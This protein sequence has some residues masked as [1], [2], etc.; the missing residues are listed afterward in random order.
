MGIKHTGIA[1][2]A[3]G[4]AITGAIAAPPLFSNSFE[5]PETDPSAIPDAR[6][7][8]VVGA[9]REAARAASERAS[10]ARRASGQAKRLAGL[11]SVLG[12][13]A[14]PMTVDD[15]TV[16]TINRNGFGTFGTVQFPSGAVFIG[17]VGQGEGRYAPS[18]ESK[19]T[20]FSGYVWGVETAYPRPIEGIFEFKTGESFTGTLSGS[21]ARG[22]YLSADGMRRFVGTMIVEADSPRPVAGIVEDRNRGLLAV[23]RENRN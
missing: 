21:E 23:V 15:Q 8:D 17:E 3:Y 16:A 2:L 20:A 12:V 9:G 7:T 11:K 18:P 6:L 22:I 19:L 1:A 10:A 4:L 13:N 14:K 5:W